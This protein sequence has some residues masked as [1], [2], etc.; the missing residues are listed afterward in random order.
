MGGE[1]PGNPIPVPQDVRDSCYLYERARRACEIATDA[2]YPAAF[3][4]VVAYER[5][6]VKVLRRYGKAVIVDGYRYAT[7]GGDLERNRYI[8]NRAYVKGE[9]E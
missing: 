1:D 6:L 8:N 9:R 5:R 4:E 7:T 2:D 3:R